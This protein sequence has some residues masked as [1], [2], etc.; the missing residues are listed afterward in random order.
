MKTLSFTPGDCAL[1]ETPA[2][3]PKPGHVLIRLKGTILDETHLQDYRSGR[4]EAPFLICG[5]VL[6]SG[7]GVI[8][9]RRGQSVLTVHTGTLDTYLLI[10]ADRILPSS[11]DRAAACMLLGIALA[12]RAV[13]TAEEYPESTLISGAGFIGLSLCALLTTTTPWVIGESDACLLCANDLG[14]AHTKEWAQAADDLNLQPAH[15]RGFGMTLIE[16]TGRADN[17]DQA[18]FLTLK[19][20]SITLAVPGG[21]GSNDLELDATHLHYDQITW[22]ALGPLKADLI[23]SAE[24]LLEKVPD[25]LITACLPLAQI[26]AAFHELDHERGVAYL[27]SH[28]GEG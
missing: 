28:D 7:A 17:L 8:G 5:E 18:Q 20:G 23:P 21:L 9:L 6:Q 25:A 11:Q 1:H 24:K 15:E 14:A 4:H 22:K 26:N 13:S 19:G 10:A 12:A 2:P 16:T 3:S 27:I